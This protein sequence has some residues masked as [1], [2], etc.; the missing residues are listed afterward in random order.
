MNKQEP[1]TWDIYNIHGESLNRTV[2]RGT[3]LGRGEYHLVVQVWVKNSCGEVLIQ[4]RAAHKKTFPG[5]WATTAGAVLAGEDAR[6]GAVRELNEELGIS[7]SPHEL[8]LILESIQDDSISTAWLLE[9]DVT[10]AELTLQSEEVSATQWATQATI[11]R[12]IQD[13]T[14]LRLW[15]SIS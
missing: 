4:K 7:A 11:K 13:G 14:F 5:I 9:R 15:C 8:Q 1:E 3:P 2:T 12:M 6:T 10:R